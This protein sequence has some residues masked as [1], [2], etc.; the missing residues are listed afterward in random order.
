[1]PSHGEFDVTV[2]ANARQAIQTWNAIKAEV[3]ARLTEEE[4]DAFTPLGLWVFFGDQSRVNT[5][6]LY[7]LDGLPPTPLYRKPRKEE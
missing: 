6:A 1:M 4:V 7:P 5:S 3:R 2:I